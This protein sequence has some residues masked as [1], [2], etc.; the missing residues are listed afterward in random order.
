MWWLGGRTAQ[1]HASTPC[2]PAGWELS[3]CRPKAPLDVQAH[4][5]KQALAA[6]AP[7]CA[8]G[9]PRNKHAAMA[10]CEALPPSSQQ[11]PT[12]P[13][14]P[15]PTTKHIPARPPGH[16]PMLKLRSHR[17]CSKPSPRSVSATSETCDE[18]IACS[19]IWLGL[20]SK[21]ASVTR[22]RMAS[23]TCAGWVVLVVFLGWW[24]PASTRHGAQAQ[25]RR[26]RSPGGLGHSPSSAG[27]PAPA[28]TQT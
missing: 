14:P 20:T 3:R 1:G 4:M 22:S 25:A 15:H 10:C 27:W 11:F 7:G 2:T 12:P 19:A 6:Q 5:H 13:S 9:C 21:L 23:S 17:Y 8:P 16:P 24:A 28:G 26:E 18:S